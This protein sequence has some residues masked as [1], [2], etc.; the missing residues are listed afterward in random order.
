MEGGKWWTLAADF[1]DDSITG[2]AVSALN[3]VS[4]VEIGYL[5]GF[6]HEA[7]ENRTFGTVLAARLIN[8]GLI[9]CKSKNVYHFSYHGDTIVTS[10]Q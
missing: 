7:P 5:L 6:I 2:S 3:D 8:C 4:A 10:M 1:F 9:A